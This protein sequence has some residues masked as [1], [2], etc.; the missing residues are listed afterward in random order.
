M[1]KNGNRYRQK[2]PTPIDKN[3]RPPIDKNVADNTINYINNKNNNNIYIY[4]RVIEKLNNSCATSYKASSKKTQSLINAR[5]SEGFTENDFYKVIE[6]KVSD[7]K[8]TEF[9]KYLRPVTLFGSKFENYL[10]EKQIKKKVV[11]S[12][13]HGKFEE[14]S[15]FLAKR[16]GN[17]NITENE[18]RE[19]ER[20]LEDYI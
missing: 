7:W 8:G 10:N 13:Q 4:S 15:E 14:Y 12:K 9:E 19:L 20:D 1:D 16:E 18:L 11:D 2:C 5:L 17:E 6:N 3:V